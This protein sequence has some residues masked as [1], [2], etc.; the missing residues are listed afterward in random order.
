M[1]EIQQ[2]RKLGKAVVGF[3]E[4]RLNSLYQ[5]L[6][7]A[8]G[9]AHFQKLAVRLQ[10]FSQQRDRIFRAGGRFHF[11]SFVLGLPLNNVVAI[12]RRQRQHALRDELLDKVRE[13]C[14]AVVP[15]GKGGVELKHGAFEQTKLRLSPAPVEGVQSAVDERDRLRKRQGTA[16]APAL[17]RASATARTGSALVQQRLV[18]DELVTVA[19]QDRAR[20]GLAADNIDALVILLQLVDQSHEI[21]VAADDGEGVDVIARERHLQS[22]ERQI[23]VGAVLVAARRGVALYHLDTALREL[24]GFGCLPAPVGIGDLGRDL[25]A[26]LDA[27]QH[28][29][30]VELAVQRGF[31]PDFYVVV[32][33]EYCEV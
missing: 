32:I 6:Y 15:F 24:P 28:A 19:L 21:A 16:A 9:N 3:V 14:G 27:V 29:L 18:T 33:N 25:A 4:V 10:H 23:D 22:V 5:R 8:S 31:D 20:E 13:G 7:L 30:D 11:Q 26:L 1:G 17:R 12:N 2:F